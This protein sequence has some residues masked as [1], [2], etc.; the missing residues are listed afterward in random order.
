MNPE[1]FLPPPQRPTQSTGESCA[2]FS[3]CNWHFPS[4]SAENKTEAAEQCLASPSFCGA[5]D[6]GLD[7]V[8]TEATEAECSSGA[9]ACIHNNGAAL[10]RSLPRLTLLR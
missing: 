4:W 8:R 9:V 5:S 3:T 7:Y 2:A 10:P 6:N 1:S